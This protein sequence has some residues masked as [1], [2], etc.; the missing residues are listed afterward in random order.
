M[1][2]FFERSG[3]FAGRT[4]TAELDTTS[5]SPDEAQKIRKMVEEAGF[6]HLPASI[7]APARGADA[8]EYVVTVEEQGKQHTVRATEMTVPDALRP[9]LEHLTQV[10]R[11]KR[12]G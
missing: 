1:R 8:L 12:G 3:G 6:F 5:L 2:I 7:P 11:A 10:A 9:L 4:L